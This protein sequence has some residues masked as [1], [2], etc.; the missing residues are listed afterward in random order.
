M[1]RGRQSSPALIEQAERMYV[2]QGLTVR[3]IA[4]LLDGAAERTLY[5]WHGR[6]EWEAKRQAH[7]NAEADLKVKVRRLE[8][9]LADE[10]LKERP[11]PQLMHGLRNALAILRPPAAVAKEEMKREAAEAARASTVERMERARAALAEAGE[12]DPAGFDLEEEGGRLL[13]EQVIVGLQSGEIDVT[14]LPRV[15]SDW[16]KFQ[17]SNVD[18]ERFRR[19][20]REKAAA[21]ADRAADLGRSGG[22]SEETV[23]RIREEIYGIV[24]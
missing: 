12:M 21:A 23:R 4:E 7:I 14:T 8:T 24:D 13:A 3:R 1:P 17:K 15:L 16:A 6:Y 22:L 11:D 9:R 10:A 5:D 18:R 20:V 2:E 19:E